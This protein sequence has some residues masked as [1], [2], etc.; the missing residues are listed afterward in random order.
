M[1]R[2]LAEVVMSNELADRPLGGVDR[3]VEVDEC[4]LTRRK[5][6]RGRRMK[7]GSLC[8]LGLYERSTDLGVHFQVQLQITCKKRLQVALRS[9]QNVICA[10]LGLYR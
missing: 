6:H 1:C 3:E 9:R 7:T 4:Y 5:Y 2:E 8:I 10:G